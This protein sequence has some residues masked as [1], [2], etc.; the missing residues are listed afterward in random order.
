MRA[1]CCPVYGAPEIMRLQDA[2][3]PEPGPEDVVVRVRAAGVSISDCVVRSGRVKPLMWIPFR[4]FVGLRGPRNPI[5]GMELSGEIEAVGAKVKHWRPGDAIFAFTGRRF[6]AYAEYA[7]LREGGRYLPSDCAIA[8]KPANITYAEAA[9]APSRAMLAL[10][11]LEK[12]SIRRGQ[13]ILIYGASSGV[14]VFAVQLAKHFGAE[15]TGVA[16]PAHLELVR[17]LGAD[18]V[19]DYTGTSSAE[20]DGPY[21]LVFDAVG[22]SK[23]SALK[24]SC[25][26]ALAR[27]GKSLS[28][29]RVARMPVNRL[30]SIRR[31]I[32]ERV[33]RP[34]LD[35]VYPFE[36]VA[37]AHRY[38]ENRHKG[39]GVA[40]EMSASP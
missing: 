31:L 1:I 26:A 8:R 23:T 9:T 34:V 19:L 14:G 17:S 33:I 10:H 36:E 3:V 5:L 37:Q 35:R 28:V 24:T 6:G 18:R 16:G 32:E 22:N 38:V 25:A 29:D 30:D 2:T 39:G 4:I 11:L 40:I 12:A 13:K 15:V 7:C 20:I 27:D 21:D